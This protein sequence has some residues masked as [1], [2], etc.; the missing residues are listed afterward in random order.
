[1]ERALAGQG[2]SPT[3]W[4]AAETAIYKTYLAT[5]FAGKAAAALETA[6]CPSL[7]AQGTLATDFQIFALVGVHRLLK[8][9]P[10]IGDP[11]YEA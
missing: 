2:A 1:M 3:E 9:I 4:Q 5:F 11:A 10:V 7:S 8:A 6:G